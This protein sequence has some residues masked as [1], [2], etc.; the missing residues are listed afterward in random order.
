MH[1]TRAYQKWMDKWEQMWGPWGQGLEEHS[2][3]E[4]DEVAPGGPR[5]SLILRWIPR[6]S[7]HFLRTSCS[8]LI[9]WAQ[10]ELRTELLAFH[11]WLGL[12]QVHT[13]GRRWYHFSRVIY[14]CVWYLLLLQIRCCSPIN[15]LVLLQI[16]PYVWW[17][18]TK[19]K[20]IPEC[21]IC[22]LTPWRYGCNQYILTTS[23]LVS[24]VTCNHRIFLCQSSTVAQ[25]T[26]YHRMYGVIGG[27]C[28]CGSE[29]G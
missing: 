22:L 24:R 9:L 10:F 4:E 26:S 25:S 7:M 13:R 16:Q 12:G 23:M 5:K 21:K 19:N 15:G 18:S 11:L 2:A 28:L 1:T 29:H 3:A 27:L 17:L 14:C 6:I 8:S 20:N